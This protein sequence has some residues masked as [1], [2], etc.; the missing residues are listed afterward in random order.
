MSLLPIPNSNGEETKFI[1]EFLI[2]RVFKVVTSTTKNTAFMIFFKAV[3]NKTSI[4]PIEVVMPV[5]I[6]QTKAHV[7]I[8]PVMWKS[9]KKGT[10]K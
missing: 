8:R 6:C 3:A 5:L 2:L 7:D 4:L 1:L 9:Q 10:E